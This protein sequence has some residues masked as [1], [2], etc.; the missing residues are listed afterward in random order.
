[1]SPGNGRSSIDLH[2]VSV[3]L[4]C[5]GVSDDVVAR[6]EICD[7]SNLDVMIFRVPTDS[8]HQTI[9]KWLDYW[10]EDNMCCTEE[11]HELGECFSADL[12]AVIVPPIKGAFLLLAMCDV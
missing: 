5:D 10:P 3:S 6:S 4:M 2:D 8:S 12:G 1:M 11:L 7:F 9:K